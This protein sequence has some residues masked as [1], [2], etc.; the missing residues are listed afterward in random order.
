MVP[1][2]TRSNKI[3]KMT[4]NIKSIIIDHHEIYRPYPKSDCLINPK[5]DTNYD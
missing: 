5:K 2:S 3:F 1:H 4:K